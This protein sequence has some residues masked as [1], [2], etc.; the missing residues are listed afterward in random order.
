MIEKKSYANKRRKILEFEV[1][2]KVFLKVSAVK[3][4]RC[5]NFKGKLSPCFVGPYDIV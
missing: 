1:V 3:G 2:D 4:T 5:F